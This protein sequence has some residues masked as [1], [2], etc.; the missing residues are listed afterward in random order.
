MAEAAGNSNYNAA[1]FQ[2]TKRFSQGYQ[3]SMNYTL[4]KSE[5]DAPEQNLVATQVGNSV[6]SDPSNRGRDKGLSLAD[7]RHTF[8]TSLVAMPRFKLDN[9]TLNYLSNNN[10]VGIIL[11]A[12]SGERFNIVSTTDMNLDGFTGSDRPVGI[13]RDSGKTP[14]QFNMD[15]R[16]SRFVEFNERY[17]LEV[18]G[19]FVNLFNVNSYFQFNNLAVPTNPDGTLT[20]GTLP[21]FATRSLPTSLDS[22]QFQLGFK[23]KF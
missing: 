11:T 13:V 10:Q 21:D 4:S 19:E 20:G 9:K 16:Y 23:F 8:V 7:Q 2:L 12:N 14:K 1:T 18:F 6:A 5:D 3:F 15:M 17:K 22:R